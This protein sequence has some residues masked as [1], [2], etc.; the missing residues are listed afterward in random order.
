MSYDLHQ[1]IRSPGP[2]TGK[3]GKLDEIDN[4]PSPLFKVRTA[5]MPLSANTHRRSNRLF[6]KPP[7]VEI[8]I[9][10]IIIII[11]TIYI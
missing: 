9:I 1:E 8:I 6:L 7:R 4:N 2:Y 11:I 5:G 10:I 3:V